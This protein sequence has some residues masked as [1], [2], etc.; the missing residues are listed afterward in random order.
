MVAAPALGLALVF[1]AA[2]GAAAPVSNAPPPPPCS[3][4]SNITAFF[5]DLDGTMYKPGG[6]IPGARPFVQW[7]EKTN[8]SFVFLSNSG[9]KGVEGVRAKFMTPPYVLQSKPIG[10]NQ[11]YTGASAVAAWL[12]DHAPRGSRL[13]IVQGQAK[14][15]STTDSFV[16]VMGRLVPTALLASWEW[17]T[18]LNDTEIASWAADSSAGHPTFV[19]LSNDGL[20]SDDADPVTHRPGYT[21]WSYSLFAHAEQLLENGAKLVHQANDAAPWP[22]R[23]GGLVLDTPGPGPFVELLKSAMYPKVSWRP[24]GA[25]GGAGRSPSDE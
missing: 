13:F 20:V 15:G 21:D 25:A 24:R 14:Y 5:V 7:L 4:L 2:T 16:R 1:V 18:D 11:A 23:K 8:K 6:L 3:A 17:R 19:V 22:L 12:T 9:A 10:L